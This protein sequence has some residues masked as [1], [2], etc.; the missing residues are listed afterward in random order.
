MERAKKIVP[1]FDLYWKHVLTC[2]GNAEHDLMNKTVLDKSAERANAFA[3]RTHR[4]QS[5]PNP[6]SQV[7]NKPTISLDTDSITAAK[8]ANGNSR[9]SHI[10]VCLDVRVKGKLSTLFGSSTRARSESVTMTG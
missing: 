4:V 8:Q 9:D 10:T 1:I 3:A 7:Q 2:V 6:L 5:R